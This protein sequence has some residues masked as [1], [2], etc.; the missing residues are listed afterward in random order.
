MNDFYVGMVVKVYGGAGAGQARVVTDYNG[1]TKVASV[2]RAW[3]TNPDNTSAYA[4]LSLDAPRVDANAEVTAASV[5][6]AVGSVTGGVSVTTNNDKTG[7]RLSGTGVDD[8]WDEP[9]SGHTTPA[10]FGFVFQPV[11]TGTAQGGFGQTITLDAGASA[12]NDFYKGTLLQIVGG[13]GAGQAR[14]IT[15][16]DGTT[17]DAIVGE[18]WAED[19]DATSDF[20]IHGAAGW[21]LNPTERDL[22]ADHALTLDW[23]AL[24]LSPAT[25]CTLQAL[26][27]VRN[28]WQASGS[29]LTVYQE[30][31]TTAA[32]T[33]TLTES[34]GANPVT[35]VDPV[36]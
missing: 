33:A 7:Y 8:I 36:G 16:Y 24:T 31:D 20:V 3:G 12:V 30:D 29:T 28:R 19:P 21:N 27:F 18:A 14:V 9:F 1:T 22:I 15:L 25:R 17:K 6:G 26:R 13:T 32:W 10:T 11:R 34:A 35:Q 5:T 23:S 2:G 4:V